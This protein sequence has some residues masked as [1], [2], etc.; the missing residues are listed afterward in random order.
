M[1]CS[2]SFLVNIIWVNIFTPVANRQI[3]EDDFDIIIAVYMAVKNEMSLQYIYSFEFDFLIIIINIIVDII[4]VII[5]WS[6]IIKCIILDS[7]SNDTVKKVYSKW[8]FEYF[9]YVA[10]ES[11]AITKNVMKNAKSFFIPE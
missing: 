2:F 7:P 9:R 10:N 1:D 4:V 5:I 8:S 3:N 11:P 6:G